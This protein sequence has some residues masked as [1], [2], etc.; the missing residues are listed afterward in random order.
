[1]P[2]HLIINLLRESIHNH[3]G[4]QLKPFI[5]GG[6]SNVWMSKFFISIWPHAVHLPRLVTSH[7]RLQLPAWLV[8]FFG[9]QSCDKAVG[10]LLQSAGDGSYTMN[11][12]N[13]LQNIYIAS[14]WDWYFSQD[15]RLSSY[16]IFKCK[17]RKG[18]VS[19][20]KALQNLQKTITGLG[21]RAWPRNLWQISVQTK[22]VSAQ[23]FH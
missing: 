7:S 8:Q 2:S 5:L 14:R 15:S 13:L 6:F 20:E 23:Q 16:C 19:T 9:S 12:R 21:S 22:S 11:Q 17:L 3:S 18:S 4:M 10:K 1:M